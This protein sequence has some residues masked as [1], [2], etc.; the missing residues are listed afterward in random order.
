MRRLAFSLVISIAA[1]IVTYAFAVVLVQP[2]AIAIG[3][4]DVAFV[5]TSRTVE[6]ATAFAAL[7]ALVGTLAMTRGPRAPQHR[8]PSHG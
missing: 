7:V 6:Y 1:A 5:Y 8:A 3:D 4:H 2:D